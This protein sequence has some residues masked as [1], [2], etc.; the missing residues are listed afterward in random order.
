LFGGQLRAWQVCEFGLFRDK[1]ELVEVPR[2][3]PE[4]DSALVRVRAAGVNF[5]DT[6]V[7]A[8]TYQ[9]RP[10]LPF[11]P[12][13]EL[14]GD[15][16]QLGADCRG[17][18]EGDRVICWTDLGAFKEF[19]SVPSGHMFRVPPSMTDAEAAVF[20]ISYQTAFLSLVHRAKLTA[21]EVLLVHAGAG[22]VGSAAIQLGKVFGATVIATTSSSRK[23]AICRELGADHTVNYSSLDFVE[24]VR[25]VTV[26]RGANVIVDPVGGEIF[27]RSL[28]CI[29]S[30]GR[31]MPIGFTS[32]NIPSLGVNRILLKNISVVGFYWGQYW[33]D[34]PS[35]I[36]ATQVKL[37]SLYEQGV[38][39]PLIGKVF[40]MDEL[41][42]A[43][44]SLHDRT[45][46]GK[47]IIMM[48]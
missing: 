2:P 48:T 37:N 27:E 8:G 28:K 32:G 15:V 21:G 46:Y 3:V 34:D 5:P 35:L 31:L 25:R 39:R 23:E 9:V 1:L 16:V 36:H 10:K 13:F 33:K 26:T 6:L 30:E 44:A 41:P 18:N 14:V 11:T 42:N 38:I 20:L 7:I 12:G 22:A 29:A 47:H 45:N 43:L 17:V 4:K 24:E 40:K 19:V